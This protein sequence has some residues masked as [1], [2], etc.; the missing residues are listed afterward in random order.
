MH[1]R[2]AQVQVPMSRHWTPWVGLSGFEVETDSHLC[3]ARLEE[4]AAELAQATTAGEMIRVQLDDAMADAA[5]WKAKY[6]EFTA[7]KMQ[8][9]FANGGNTILWNTKLNKLCV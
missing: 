2:S 8:V 1:E 6:I 3:Q 9:L 5:A 4:M 7:S